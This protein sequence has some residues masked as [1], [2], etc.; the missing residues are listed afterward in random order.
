MI[1]I[2][3]VVQMGDVALDD[4]EVDVEIEQVYTPIDARVVSPASPATQF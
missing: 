1:D 3:D 2:S 4:I